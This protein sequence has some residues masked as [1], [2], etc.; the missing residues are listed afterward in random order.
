M[1]KITKEEYGEVFGSNPITV[2]DLK[3]ELEKY[4]DNLVVINRLSSFDESISFI[5]LEDI[6]YW[7]ENIS[8]SVLMIR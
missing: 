6:V 7:A 2:K 4:D 1:R 5:K 3:K 8:G